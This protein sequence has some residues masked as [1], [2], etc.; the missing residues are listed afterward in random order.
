MRVKLFEATV[1][2]PWTADQ[3]AQTL[4]IC[5]RWMGEAVWGGWQPQPQPLLND[6]V[7]TTQV[8]KNSKIWPKFC[9]YN[10]VWLLPYAHGQHV[11]VLKHF[12]YVSDG[13]R[14]QFAMAVSLNHDLMT[15]FWL[16]KWPRSPK[17]EL[18]RCGH[19][20]VWL[21]THAHGQHINVLKNFA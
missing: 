10:C 21:L 3:C 11:N 7:L 18:S 15:S 8:T 20:C 5:L 2:C 12:V 17:S 9:G 14:N 1:L 4:C 19:N 6:I 13:Y 16:H